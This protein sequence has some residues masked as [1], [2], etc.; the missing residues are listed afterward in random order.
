MKV[1]MHEIIEVYQ[2]TDVGEKGVG[3]SVFYN[4]DAMLFFIAMA[5]F[6][7]LE[8]FHG[9]LDAIKAF[10]EKENIDTNLAATYI[11]DGGSNQVAPDNKLLN[12]SSRISKMIERMQL[13]KVYIEKDMGLF[14]RV[15]FATMSKKP[16]MAEK[17]M[18][19]VNYQELERSQIERTAS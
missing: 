7:S 4:E 10:V 1:N 8:H 19:G 6:S 18:L 14:L 16:N 12:A 13:P 9:A 2:N 17:I 11:T 5:P 15:L 3:L